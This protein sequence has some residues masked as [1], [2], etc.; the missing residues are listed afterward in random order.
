MHHEIP[1]E[2]KD[3]DRKTEEILAM[4]LKVFLEET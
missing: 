4:L 2:I 3:F 1:E